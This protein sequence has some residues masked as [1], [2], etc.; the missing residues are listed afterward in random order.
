MTHC[1][2]LPPYML[3]HMA[4]QT[5]DPQV[6]AVALETI[7]QSAMMLG[8]REVMADNPG[9]ASE[10]GF[11]H[12]ERQVFDCKGTQQLP[13]RLVLREG[14]PVPPDDAVREAYEG[15]RATYDLFKTYFGRNSIDGRGMRMLSS[16]SFGRAYCN[17]FW[18]G[19]QMVYGKGDQ[20]LFNRFTVCVDIIA[21]ELTHG[22]TQFSARLAYQGQS[23]AL[24]ESV[25][26]CFGSMA[27]Q[28]VL[29]QDSN[30]ADWL[31]GQ[32]LFTP[33]VKARALRDMKNPG[34]AYDDLY[35]GKDPQPGHMKDFVRTYEDAGGVHANSGIP[36]RAFYL[37]ASSLAGK[38]YEAPGA[39]WYNALLTLGDPYAAFDKFALRTVSVAGEL[40]GQGSKHRQAARDAW[41]AV[42]VL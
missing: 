8:T 2:V 5:N 26:D 41:E 9:V 27:K 18:Q 32:G 13:G 36:N 3:R 14:G 16:V 37:V 29:G 12:M 25:S 19:R 11:D 42:G 1:Q 30:G 7:Q 21:H 28:M 10:I 38:S 17:A 24:N 33:A 40:Y 15:A 6:Q 23:G 34:T 22:V 31:I 20:K 4:T 39:I 35:L